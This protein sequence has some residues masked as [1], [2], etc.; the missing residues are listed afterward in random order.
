MASTVEQ[1]EGRSSYSLRTFVVGSV[2]PMCR[3]KLNAG[4]IQTGLAMLLCAAGPDAKGLAILGNE[5]LALRAASWKTSGSLRVHHCIMRLAGNTDDGAGRV[6][7]V[8]PTLRCLR[9]A[10]FLGGLRESMEVEGISDVDRSVLAGA[11]LSLVCRTPAHAAIAL[12][13]W[14]ERVV[15]LVAE[16]RRFDVVRVALLLD[17]DRAILREKILNTRLLASIAEAAAEDRDVAEMGVS[18]RGNRKG[19]VDAEDRER[20]LELIDTSVLLLVGT[21]HVGAEKDGLLL[22]PTTC[23]VSCTHDVSRRNAVLGGGRQ[24]TVL[25]VPLE[26]FTLHLGVVVA[27][28]I[29]LVA[30]HRQQDRDE[31]MEAMATEEALFEQLPYLAKVKRTVQAG[32]AGGAGGT[33]GGGAAAKAVAVSVAK[34][35][36]L[37]RLAA[38]LAAFKVDCEARIRSLEGKKEAK[39]SRTC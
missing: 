34:D 12:G 18:L 28:A 33:T 31:M 5:G 23:D 35:K 37:T 24:S 38:E 10:T 14:R 30:K 2:M 17:E 36:E 13:D 29:R 25:D 21:R 8:D 1:L 3:S 11:A 39:R 20:A 26:M 22:D 32:G 7:T 27:A 4:R 19:W 15:D 9:S 6:A 16:T